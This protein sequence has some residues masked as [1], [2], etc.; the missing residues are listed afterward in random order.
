MPCAYLPQFDERVG[1]CS[2]ST[3][4]TIPRGINIEVVATRGGGSGAHVM[5]D[6]KSPYGDDA[7]STSKNRMKHE[8]IRGGLLLS[9]WR[10]VEHS[11]SENSG[12]EVLYDESERCIRARCRGKKHRGPKAATADDE[13][14]RQGPFARPIGPTTG[15]S[16]SGIFL[17]FDDLHPH[18]H[19]RD[20]TD[21]NCAKAPAK[22]VKSVPP[23]CV[24]HEAFGASICLA[25]TGLT[26]GKAYI[27]Q[28]SSTC[29]HAS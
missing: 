16:M 10:A 27:I 19:R 17:Q 13:R 21:F 6:V 9:P 5:V 3:L 28:H 1:G 7:G 23:D 18:S 14:R 26:L 15:P 8:A 24:V 20:A 12:S 4:T 25:A 11:N 22:H 29:R 2:T